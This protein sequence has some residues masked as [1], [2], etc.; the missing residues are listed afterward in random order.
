[1]Y[2]PTKTGA[3]T[4]NGAFVSEFEAKYPKATACLVEDREA[5]LT[6]FTYPSEHCTHLRTTNPIESLSRRSGCGSG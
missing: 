2:A 3:E 1:M 6:F 5:L 4:A